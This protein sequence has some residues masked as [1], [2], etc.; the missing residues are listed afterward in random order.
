[1]TGLHLQ[2]SIHNKAQAAAARTAWNQAQYG[3][4]N[5]NRNTVEEILQAAAI[6]PRDEQIQKENRTTC[7]RTEKS[8][9]GVVGRFPAVMNT[10]KREKKNV[11]R[12]VNLDGEH[13]NI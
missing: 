3:A 5:K 9:T 4:L 6:E 1:M 2:P 10:H 11:S 8:L 7:L 12:K 13:K